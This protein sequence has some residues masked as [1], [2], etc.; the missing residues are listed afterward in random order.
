MFL[1]MFI[2]LKST[3]IL[4]SLHQDLLIF[5]Y[6]ELKGKVNVIELVVTCVLY[7]LLYIL[8]YYL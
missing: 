3:I 1:C 6:K 4:L 7:F 2:E 5:C 8:P